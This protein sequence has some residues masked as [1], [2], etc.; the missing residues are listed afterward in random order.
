MLLIHQQPVHQRP[1]LIV[2]IGIC[3]VGWFT[4][5]TAG[6]DEGAGGTAILKE[7]AEIALYDLPGTA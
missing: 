4:V 1:V 2:G 7:E 6:I 5:H 3:I